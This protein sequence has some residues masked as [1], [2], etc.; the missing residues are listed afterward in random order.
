MATNQVIL[1]VVAYHSRLIACIND[2]VIVYYI[3]CCRL[4]VT[5]AGGSKYFG[6]RSSFIIQYHNVT[7]AFTCN[8]LKN[9]SCPCMGTRQVQNTNCDA[10]GS[11]KTTECGAGGNKSINIIFICCYM[12]NHLQHTS[13]CMYITGY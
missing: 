5:D 7:A 11:K 1:A 9:M 3:Y 12:L 6:T 2:I 10:G 4:N 8:I 13:A